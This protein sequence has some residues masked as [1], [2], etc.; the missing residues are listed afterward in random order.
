MLSVKNI[1]KDNIVLLRDY[2]SGFMKKNENKRYN[3]M[4][5]DL[6]LQ[7]ISTWKNM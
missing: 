4:D 1:K 7:N 6:E 2:I 3:A 5:H